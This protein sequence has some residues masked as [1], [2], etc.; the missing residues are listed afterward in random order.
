VLSPSSVSASTAAPPSVQQIVNQYPPA[1]R[2]RL[3][4]PLKSKDQRL[5]RQ[6]WLRDFPQYLPFVNREQQ[7]TDCVSHFAK[8]FSE[9]YH[10]ESKQD[11]EADSSEATHGAPN[12]AKDAARQVYQMVIAAG[13]PGIGQLPPDTFPPICSEPLSLAC[14]C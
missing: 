3:S 1:G 6:V 12:P 7:V 11:G 13:G 8:L 10:T 2:L 14:L 4:Y 5:P 9:S